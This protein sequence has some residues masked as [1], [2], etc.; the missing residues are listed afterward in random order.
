MR[1]QTKVGKLPRF[2]ECNYF[3]CV[4]TLLIV[5]WMVWKQL[6][7][8][9]RD[10]QRRME[11]N[12]FNWMD[13]WTRS[14]RYSRYLF[15][16]GMLSCRFD[17]LR[18]IYPANENVVDVLLWKRLYPS[19]RTIKVFVGCVW[20]NIFDCVCRFCIRP[21]HYDTTRNSICSMWFIF[22]IL[23]ELEQLC[24]INLLILP[25]LGDLSYSIIR[26]IHC[27]RRNKLKSC[28]KD[29]G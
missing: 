3:L 16:Y 11:T 23:I 2:I 17:L 24:Y 26:L 25:E 13:S 28:I 14:W 20:Y 21:V 8:C 7:N 18:N 12:R 29:D 19:I 4:C 1:E 27:Y 5:G 22:D 9:V 6:S 10:D 15:W